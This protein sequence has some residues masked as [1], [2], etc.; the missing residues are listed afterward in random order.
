MSNTST[1]KKNMTFYSRIC[2]ERTKKQD[3]ILISEKIKM[4]EKYEKISKNLLKLKKD[5]TFQ[6]EEY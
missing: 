1:K 2:K 3:L 5:N 4:K 6:I